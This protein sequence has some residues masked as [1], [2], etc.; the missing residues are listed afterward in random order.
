MSPAVAAVLRALEGRGLRKVGNGWTAL[1][2]THD[3]KRSSLSVGEGEG[4]RALVRCHA[5]CETTAV[6]ERLGLRMADLMP[7][8]PAAPSHV[9][10]V[11]NDRRDGN[12][13]GS[14]IAA[15]YAYRDE[16]CAVLYEV[17]RFEP[18]AFRQRRPDG[19]GGWVWSLGDVRRVLYR[20]PELLAAPA[21]TV[22]YVVEGEKDADALAALGLVATTNGGGAGKWRA[23]YGAAL[24][25]R[26]VVV[27]PDNDDPG[28]KHA[29]EVRDALRGVA[30]RVVVIEL[31]GLPDKGDVSDW[32]AAVHT[33]DELRSL[34]VVKLDSGPPADA[35]EAARSDPRPPTEAPAAKPSSGGARVVTLATVEPREVEW[36]WPGRLPAGMVAVLDGPP[37]AG[38]STIVVDIIARLTTGQPLPN[39]ACVSRPVADVVMLGHEDSPEHTI[40]P[41]L[42]AAGADPARVHLLDAV[43]GRLPRLPDDAE[44]IEFVIREKHARL[45]VVRAI[46]P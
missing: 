25:G 28:R 44:A 4:G 34:T 5:G 21:D 41:R 24:R 19:N 14:R 43:G 2:P 27:L 36:L 32:L 13:G 11:S 8:R 22:V 18:K 16:G 29:A 1:C 31:D 9:R 40:R 12:G 20:L 6:V 7:E 39:E 37:G 42:D 38:K 46:R 3:D 30:T 23:E 33:A 26:S 45:L 15:T 35:G 10:P 17:V